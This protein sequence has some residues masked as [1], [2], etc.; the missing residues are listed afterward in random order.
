MMNR[1]H[2]FVFLGLGFCALGA[3]ALVGGCTCAG[4]HWNIGSFRWNGSHMKDGVDLPHEATIRL[5]SKDKPARLTLSFEEADVVVE[6]DATVTGVEAEF[7]V[8]EKTAGDASLA[9][10]P[11]GIQVKSASG[12]PVLVDSAKIRVPPGT[13]VR[14]KTDAGG[15]TI[16]GIEGV[17]DVDAESDAGKI[18]LRG[19][20]KVA[21]VSG[22][23]DAG[24]VSL[25]DSSGL[26]D[27]TLETSAGSVTL[28]SVADAKDV[29]LSSD[30]GSVR[31]ERLGASTSLVCESDAG[32][33]K[34]T[35]VHTGDARLKT[36]L[37]AVHAEDS[38][39]D[40]VYAHSSMGGVRLKGCTYKTKDVGTD[41][42]K[43]SDEK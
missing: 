34:V 22:K 30:A 11:D 26:G 28:R 43:V 35:D 4:P 14:V 33:V 24:A 25:A 8:H 32:S 15:V 27:V 17:D 5:S 2:V 31:A 20:K 13:P 42:G 29:K 7:V 19:L 21:T 37:G 18:E 16:S 1:H 3:A 6:G 10:G 40:H 36:D 12:S 23:T 38:T 39:F 9:A 41:L